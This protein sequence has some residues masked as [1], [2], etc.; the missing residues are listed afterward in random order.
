MRMDM[1]RSSLSV[2]SLSFRDD[3]TSFPRWGHVCPKGAT[4]KGLLAGSSMEN[5]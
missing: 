4:L 5:P 3:I 2:R 1:E